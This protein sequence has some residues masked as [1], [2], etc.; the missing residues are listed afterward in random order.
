MYSIEFAFVATV[1]IYVSNPDVQLL[2]TYLLLKM[3]L[4]LSKAN[5]ATALSLHN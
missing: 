1:C 3:K 2:E 4:Y 5:H